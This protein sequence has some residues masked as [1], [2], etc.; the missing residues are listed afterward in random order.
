MRKAV[1]MA[2]VLVVLTA[3]S[4]HGQE[5][6]KLGE[7]ELNGH[8][9]QAE[10]YGECCVK[11]TYEGQTGYI[12]PWPGATQET[13][14]TAWIGDGTPPVTDQGLVCCSAG[15]TYK[16][17]LELTCNKLVERHQATLVERA[18]PDSQ[19]PTQERLRDYLDALIRDISP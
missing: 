12:G 2:A 15:G 16:E 5:S 8:T 10:T 7:F 9:F 4:G 1:F 11:V 3:T 18:A 14:V 19:P 6:A 13:P 17:V